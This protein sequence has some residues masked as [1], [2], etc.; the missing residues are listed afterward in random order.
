[1]VALC[2]S[3]WSTTVGRTTTVAA[4]GGMATFGDLTLNKTSSG[5]GLTASA[6]GLSTATSNSFTI[7]AGTATQ[8]VFGTPPSTTIAG[9]QISP[10]EMVRASCTV[11]E[12]VSVVTVSVRVT[13][14]SIRSGAMLSGTTMVSSC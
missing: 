6:T 7:T 2:N 5:Y 9:R 11:G 10:A 3:Q 12:W 4:V 8:L 14:R 13:M 1:P